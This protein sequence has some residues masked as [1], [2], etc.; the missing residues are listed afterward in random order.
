VRDF[1]DLTWLV[2]LVHRLPAWKKKAAPVRPTETP[3]SMEPE[4]SLPE[5]AVAVAAAEQTDAV[6]EWLQEPTPEGE[7]MEETAQ[8]EELPEEGSLT[9]EEEEASL[10]DE[11]I[12]E[13][14][15]SEL[16]GSGE[17]EQMPDFLSDDLSAAAIGRGLSSDSRCARGRPACGQVSDPRVQTFWPHRLR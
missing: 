9:G 2:V 11:D 14:T 15:S 12:A 1:A 8:L 13:I 7:G 10:S 6:P 5:E 17:E 4:T 16:G 3:P